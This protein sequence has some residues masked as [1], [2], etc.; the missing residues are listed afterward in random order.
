MIHQRVGHWQG[1]RCWRDVMGGTASDRVRAESGSAVHGCQAIDPRWPTCLFLDL[2]EHTE[3]S[4]LH[5]MAIQRALSGLRLLQALVGDG[6]HLLQ[7]FPHVGA[8]R[9]PRRR[10]AW[11]RGRREARRAWR[12]VHGWRGRASTEE[13][14]GLGRWCGRRSQPPSGTPSCRQPTRA[15]CPR[16]RA[17]PPAAS[18]PPAPRGAWYRP[19]ACP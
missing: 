15:T 13:P 14:W 7:D 17:P 1:S 3:E 16:S 2:T 9:G 4:S 8:R 10:A 5:P 11:G 19:Q 6:Q 18:Q 12:G